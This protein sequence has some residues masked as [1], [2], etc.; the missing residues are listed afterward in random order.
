MS[1]ALAHD[2]AEE[3][4]YYAKACLK[5]KKFLEKWFGYKRYFVTVED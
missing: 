3:A 1:G 2:Q 5:Y 4:R